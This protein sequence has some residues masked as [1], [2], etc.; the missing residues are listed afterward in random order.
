[1]WAQEAGLQGG[2]VLYSASGKTMQIPHI[3][4][5][6]QQQNMMVFVSQVVVRLLL[7]A[8]L[9]GA[10]G[11]EREM[12][13]RPAGL[14]TNMFIC[15]GSALFTVLSA[16]LATSAGDSTRI[17]AQIITGIGFIGAGSILHSRGSVT[18]LTTAATVF[19]VAAIG[20]A[21]GGGLFLVA[22]FSTIIVLV[23]L[24]VLGVWERRFTDKVSIMT[25]TVEG[26]SPEG[27]VGE[28]SSTLERLKLSVSSLQLSTAN[29]ACRVA[30]TVRALQDQQ[31]S[32]TK[33]LESCVP[34]KHFSS[35]S[36]SEQE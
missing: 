28:V 33:S 29:G 20:M 8:F 32:L 26:E 18:G 31:Q 24:S 13:H 5:P 1:L 6:Q 21:C 27:V 16:K 19:V 14:R 30:F 2:F 15:L 22:L 35:I 3:F 34:V 12:K 10:I 4:D 11:L 9:G 7:A 25:Y 36:I 23:A 17:A